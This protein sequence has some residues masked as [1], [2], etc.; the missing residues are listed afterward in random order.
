MPAAPAARPNILWISF[1][2]TSPR[3]GCHDDKV[4]RTPNM[5]KLAGNPAHAEALQRLRGALDDWRREYDRYGEISEEEMVRGW[6]P[7]GQQPPT[8]APLAFPL[9]DENCAQEVLDAKQAYPAPL[10]VQLHCSTQGASLGWQLDGEK[11]WRLY[12]EPLRL[13]QS[14]TLR[15]KAIR[16]GYR[17]S[18]VAEWKIKV[19]G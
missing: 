15:A 2:D 10:M 11:D 7:G 1:E 14:V 6:Y 5:D 12:T 13:T 4:A 16:I 18:G 19:Q 3:F 8:A 9:T 17:E